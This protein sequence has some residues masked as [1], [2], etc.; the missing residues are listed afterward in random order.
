MQKV[1]GG[2]VFRWAVAFYG[3]YVGQR[4]RL[5]GYGNVDLPN[6]ALSPIDDFEHNMGLKGPDVQ[7]LQEADTPFQIQVERSKRALASG[8]L[9]TILDF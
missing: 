7:T 4:S 5:C 8:Y 2:F 3:T 9:R 6:N 1:S